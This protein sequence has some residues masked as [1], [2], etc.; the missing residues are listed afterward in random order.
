MNPPPTGQLHSGNHSLLVNPLRNNSVLTILVITTCFSQTRQFFSGNPFFFGDIVPRTRSPCTF[1]LDW[2]HWAN[3][4]HNGKMT[5]RQGSPKEF[6]G[7]PPP[8][9]SGH[10]GRRDTGSQGLSTKRETYVSIVGLVSCII[11]CHTCFVM[12]SFEI[13]SYVLPFCVLPTCFPS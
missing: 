8:P 13:L 7:F 9:V 6:E 1:F 3:L 11:P 10:C 5:F 2:L 12:E 4:F